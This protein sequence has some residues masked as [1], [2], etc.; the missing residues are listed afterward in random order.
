MSKL[1]KFEQDPHWLRLSEEHRTTISTLDGELGFSHAELR[2]LIDI[3]R[4]L[5][6]WDEPSL[7]PEQPHE[8]LTQKQKRQKVMEAIRSNWSSLKEKPNDYSTF[9]PRSDFQ[10]PHPVQMPANSERT[11][12][13]S[14]P[15]ASPKTR[16]CNLQTLDA[17]ISCG[18][19][20]SYCSI[21]SFY[22][23]GKVQFD[24]QLK[25]KLDALT[26]EPDRKYHIGTGQSSDSLMW[27]NRENSLDHL[28]AFARKHPNLCLEFKTKSKNIQWFLENDIPRNAICTWSLNPQ[29]VIDNEEHLTASLEERLQAAEKIA[30]KGTLIGFHLHPMVYYE[31]WEEGYTKMI[32]EITSRFTPEQV[33]TI[34]FGT[35]TFIKPV[36]KK[37][38][39]RDFK[40]KILQMPLVD[41]EGKFSYPYE[42]KQNMFSVAY[43]AFSE[44]HDKVFFYMCMEDIRLWNDVFG[45]EYENNDLFE[46]AML[47]SYFSKIDKLPSR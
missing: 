34:S 41:A 3:A 22:T 12:L 17:V 32:K 19:D 40:T 27:G 7:D 26:F 39:N 18:H 29:E 38:R 6:M 1:I 5:E 37:L 16:C 8:K 23:G 21:Q 28:A 24:T 30:A 35:L 2:Q 20:C 25:E 14:C 13:G 45:F 9:T 43:N 31:G 42:V 15:V 36:I 10:P 11:I 33:V 47:S 46:E 44:W 4:D